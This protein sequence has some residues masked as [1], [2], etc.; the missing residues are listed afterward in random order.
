MNVYLWKFLLRSVTILLTL[1]EFYHLGSICWRTCGSGKNILNK[2]L[3][4][5]SFSNYT[6]F[7][8]SIFYLRMV[9]QVLDNASKIADFMWI[10]KKLQRRQLVLS[11]WWDSCRAVCSGEGWDSWAAQGIPLLQKNSSA[12]NSG[13]AVWSSLACGELIYFSPTPTL[14]PR[15]SSTDL[16]APPHGLWAVLWSRATNFNQRCHYASA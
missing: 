3:S 13:L 2:Y 12:K 7:K 5:I 16:C 6:S 8:I 9:L 10:F 14:P 15:K 4:F 1:N 11:I